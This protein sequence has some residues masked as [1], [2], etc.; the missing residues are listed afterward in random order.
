M[1]SVSS[2]GSSTPLTSIQ[3]LASNIQWQDLIDQLIAADTA[4]QLTPVQDR[5]KAD[6]AA[7]GAWTT[8]GQLS[9]SLSSAVLN[10]ANGSAFSAFKVSGGTSPTT[11]ASL[12]TASATSSAAP[13]SYGVQVLGLA[14]AQQLSGN[15]VSDPTAAMSLSGQIAVGGK[16]VTI[17][18]TDSLNSIRDKINALDTGDSPSHVSAS[19]LMSGSSSARLILTSD[20]GGA[21]GIDLRDLRSSASDASVLTQLGFIDGSMANVSSDGAVRSASFASQSNAVAG[22]LTGIS[23]QPGATTVLVNGRSVSVNVQTQS[24]TDI[25]AAI[26]AQSPNSASVESITSGSTTTYR[27]KISGSVSAST[28]AASAPT[29]DLL[30]LTRGT[31]GVV[32]Q[33]VT[34][35]NTL[36]ASD[37]TTAT[38]STTLAGLKISGGNGAQSGD[39]F[40]IT[41]TKPDGTAVSL[42]ETVGASNTIGDMLTDLSTAF[43]A[44]G[45]HVTAAIVNGQIQLTDDV[46][47]DSA[48]SF[49]IAANNESGVADPTNGASL[50]FG[51][52]SVSVVG[53]QRQLAAGSDARLVVNGVQ[54]TRP[55]NTIADAITGVTLTLDQA[56]VGTTVSINVAQDTSQATSAL[57]QLV[58]AYNSMNSFVKSSTASGGA[59]QFNSSM[60]QSM[61]SIKDS[62]L[63][64]VT[65][66]PTGSPYTNAALVGLTFDSTGTLSL[67]TAALGTAL[68][69]NASAVKSLF[70]TMATMANSDFSYVGSTASSVNGSY[71]AQ[72]TQAATKASVSSTAANFSYAAGSSTDSLTISDSLSGKSGSISLATGDTP[73]SVA[74]KLNTLFAAQSMRLSASTASGILSIASSTYGH[75]PSFSLTYA[76]TGGND[77]AG[78]LGIAAGTVQNGLDVAGYFLDQDGVTHLAATGAGQVLTGTAGNTSGLAVSYAGSATSASSTLAFSAGLGGALATL[79]DQLSR[80]GDGVVSQQTAALQQQISDLDT[81][82]Q[83]VQARLDAKRAALTKQ[84]TAMETALS[85]LQSQSAALTNQINSLLSTTQLSGS[86]G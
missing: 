1:A 31:T 80:S 26:N 47:G 64:D 19:V 37:G 46:G 38:S 84:F 76:S 9:S 16:V 5:S 71:T 83:A 7:S 70:A 59:L 17:A 69:T 3:G 24:L 43:S 77:V 82:A 81:Q 25:A 49:S 13:G 68:A 51:A 4:S 40:T 66:L 67:D 28:D 56:E 18:N 44:S 36:L 15:I 27:L 52:A 6:A 11:G 73:D 39:T 50:S 23:S 21:S 86:K 65:G 2:S 8:Y 35:A 12:V 62:L 32:E 22:Q 33:Q 42:T 54:L 45:R 29:L 53:R 75:A 48:L 34:T 55:T 74:Q 63:S 10:L 78:M 57:Q 20:V 79:T 30:G 41:G 58:S 14:A 72:I 85:K 61:Q 60:R